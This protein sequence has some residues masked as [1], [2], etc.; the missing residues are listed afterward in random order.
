MR[1]T[2]VRSAMLATRA[3]EV[4]EVVAVAVVEEVAVALEV[5]ADSEER[6]ESKGIALPRGPSFGVPRFR[7]SAKTAFG[8]AKGKE[9][10]LGEQAKHEMGNIYE[11]GD[12]HLYFTPYTIS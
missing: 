2:A 3:L 6:V 12:M 5:A 8:L 7:S 4:M 1:A 11:Q 10:E 9:R